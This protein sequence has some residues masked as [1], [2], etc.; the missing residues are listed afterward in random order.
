MTLRDDDNCIDEEHPSYDGELS[1]DKSARGLALRKLKGQE[2][3]HTGT[4]SEETFSFLILA[5]FGSMSWFT[6]AVVLLVKVSCHL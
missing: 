2:L 5:N 6:G 3:Q 4:L 1:K